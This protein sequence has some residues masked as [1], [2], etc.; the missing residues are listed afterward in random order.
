MSTKQSRKAKNVPANISA[1]PAAG[2]RPALQGEA[3]EATMAAAKR[4]DALP[5]R[6]KARVRD[7]TVVEAP[8][9][10]DTGWGFELQD[11]F[12]SSSPGFINVQ[13]ATL[14]GMVNPRGANQV[15]EQHLN[16]ALALLGGIAP[17]NEL[18]AALGMQMVGTHALVT[19]LL[20]KSRSTDSREAL[21]LYVNLV[22]K[23][24]RTFVAQVEA[25]SK[26]R[27]G[28]KQQVEVRHVYV[29]ARTQNIIGTPPPL[30]GGGTQREGHPY[31][32]PYDAQRPASL[33][34]PDAERDAVPVDPGPGAQALPHARRRAGVRRSH[35]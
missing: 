10:D 16:S 17:K 7:K 21:E 23:T 29:D 20:E 19:E 6:A 30:G 1:A 25:L 32:L 34:G 4:T 35:G 24:Q 15:A 33:P 3:L 2:Q 13:L 26:L 28:G 12:A 27:G 8:Y 31:A 9:N 22:A 18:E 14:I 11:L 5:H